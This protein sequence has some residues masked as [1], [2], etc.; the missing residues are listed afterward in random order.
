M[1][2]VTLTIKTITST[3]QKKDGTP[4]VG[5][6]GPYFLCRADTEEE[7]WV[8]WFGKTTHTNQ[9][10]D[11]I[12]GTLEVTESNGFKNKNFKFA[13]STKISLERFQKLEARVMTLELSLERKFA[14]LKSDLVLETTG[15]FNTTK[16]I[17]TF[18]E[19]ANA[20]RKEHIDNDPFEG[21]D[22]DSIPF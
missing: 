14:E 13:D 6:F 18:N 7:G 15:T 3:N 16:D 1:K 2:E 20:Y 22:P 19:S 5:K 10:G 21:I 11:K 8:S 9:I 4:L 12:T 17:N